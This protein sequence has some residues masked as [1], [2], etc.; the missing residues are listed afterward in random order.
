MTLNFILGK[1]QFD[2]HE[3]MMELFKNDFEKDPQGEF[4][5]IVP[6]H[7]K[8]ESEIMML[9]DFGKIQGNEEL[10]A[11]NRV[12]CFSISRLA[13]YFLRGTDIFNTETL[14]DTKSAM[15]IRNIIDQHRS[16]LKILGGMADKSG[17]ID[18]LTSQF[19]EFQNGQV[20]P[21]DVQTVMQNK[22][23]DIFTG[24]IDELNLIYREYT[25]N[26]DQ[27]AT[28]NFK[29]DALAEFFDEYAKS[30][31]LYFYVEGFSTFTASELNVVKSI[32][33][34][35]GNINVSLNL[36]QP[37]L[38]PVEKTDFYAR[39]AGTYNQLFNL[40]NDN[41]IA[42]HNYFAD[43]ERVN[44][45]IAKLENYWVESSG[46]GQ[47]QASQLDSRNSVQIWK[48]TNKQAELSAVSTYIRQLVANQDYRYKD[49]LIL[50]RDLNQYSS[51]AAAFMDEN[52]IPY[53]IDLQR[54]MSDHPFKK[55]IDL[56]F[57]LINKGLQSDDA[58]A[59]L[60]TELIIPEHY[61]TEDIADFREAVDLLENYVLANGTTRKNWLGEEFTSD[62][63]L[64]E[65]IDA[66]LIKDYQLI[67]EIKEFIKQIYQ[68]LDAFFKVDHTALEAAGF[69][70]SFLEQYGV[71]K[72]MGNWQQQAV[73]QNDLTSAGQPEQVIEE[74]N[75]VLD[76]YV[77]V[78]GSDKFNSQSFIEILD[79]A[80]ESSQYSQI[81]STLD[82]V[83]ISEIGMVQPNNRKITFILG[84]T[85]NNMPGTSVSNGI[86][87][88]DE[89]E[90]ISENLEDG[91]YLNASDEVM[92]NSEPYL[93]D[94]T[95]TT[96]S[97]RLIFTY[98]NYTEDNKQQDLSSYVVRI[99]EHFNLHE[100]D[101]LLNPD[102]NEE[103]ENEILRYV[104]SPE[105]SLNY[106]IRVSRSAAD[107]K[108]QLS[109]QWKYIQNRLLDQ[110]P[111]QSRFAL[112]SLDYQNIPVDLKPETVAKLYGDNINVSISRL[113]TFYQN[114]YEYF[115]KYG[116]RL[117]PRSIFEINS[118]QTGSLYHAVLDGLVK[119]INEQKVNIRDLNDE[120]LFAYVKD[121][122]QEQMERSENR[123]FQSSERM[124]YISQKAQDTLLQ[125]VKAIKQQ[126]S[127]NNFIPRA[128][129]VAFGK[130]NNT[131]QDLP[132][133]SYQIPGNHWINVRGK[134]DRI[135]EMELSDADYLA[136]IDYKSSM[137]AFDFDSFLNGLTMQMPTY[138]ENLVA[139]KDKF[140]TREQV[141]IAGAFY[142]HIQNPKIQLK[143]GVNVQQELLKKFK[144]DGLIVDDE[145]LLD[146]LDN[147]LE[148]TSLI[149]PI[150]QTK[151][152]GITI[153][154]KNAISNDD[155][156]R[157]LN[158][159]KHLI[160][161]AG[162]KIYSGKLRINP[163]RDSNNRTGLQN[164]DYKSILQFDAMLP[165]NEYHEIINHGREAK[166]EVLKQIQQILEE[167]N[168]A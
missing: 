81:P 126:L 90:L 103:Q 58:I 136:V 151:S 54:K 98:P 149:L 155:L 16:D 146:N 153:N 154:K 96:P 85:V 117:Q 131:K 122:F 63:S 26:I 166:K 118:A 144:L 62:A 130:M 70:Y 50:A 135:D 120:Q 142:S 27:F 112:S 138:L 33:L 32:I 80:F 6:N 42:F 86:I 148:R 163:Y 116:L 168:N 95:F 91:K 61:Q 105:S 74:F 159:N 132:G 55:L 17:F 4:F 38:K 101:I 11:S 99:A 140:S 73:D 31:H 158:Y 66:Q 28:N 44:K 37:A 160:T 8:F 107:N 18:Q 9:N 1:N 13:W 78:F 51:F 45:D 141:K 69:L 25:E 82:A 29:L 2:H 157:I 3:K 134:I 137:H 123:I 119:V 111:E 145:E 47:I 53:F 92:N 147:L 94:L 10:V 156:F 15:I 113:E 167:E 143:K 139:N 35:C 19:T 59:L 20:T 64:D 125:L 14:T 56:L 34:N 165:E 89:R 115:L 102:P 110:D 109:N 57:S 48:S 39:P 100:Q 97:E 161:Q 52:E 152:K 106:L 127:R 49:F 79:A 75:T 164:S 24:K 21:D 12:Q 128:T 129:E 108:L 65:K 71:F 76:E 41:S 162:E 88:D 36:D 133:L 93:H 104:G 150:S 30:K 77:S 40:A 124:G 114:E 46:I 83:N 121:V 23:D 5:F 72:Q 84:A 43:Q 22:S 67:N 68:S 60:R 87:A 7:I